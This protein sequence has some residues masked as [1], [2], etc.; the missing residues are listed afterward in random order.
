MI[1]ILACK[2]S[3]ITCRVLTAVCKVLG[4]ASKDCV[5]SDIMFAEMDSNS[6]GMIDQKEFIEACKRNT[7]LMEKLGHT[8]VKLHLI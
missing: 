3:H 8:T 1:I 7:T 6:D 4:H 5:K 2:V